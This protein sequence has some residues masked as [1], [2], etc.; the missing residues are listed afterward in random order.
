LGLDGLGPHRAA[1]HNATSLVEGSL[2]MTVPNYRQPLR[3]VAPRRFRLGVDTYYL[4]RQLNTTEAEIIRVLDA[5][6]WRPPQRE[7]A[8]SL[9]QIREDRRL[10]WVLG[11]RA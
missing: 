3:E 2:E 1:L 7:P 9:A 5:A 11:G 6:R 10:D 4:A 8:P